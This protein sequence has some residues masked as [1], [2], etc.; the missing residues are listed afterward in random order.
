MFYIICIIVFWFLVLFLAY[1]FVFFFD[2]LF[3]G[4]LLFLVIGCSSLQPCII[5]VNVKAC[6]H[7]LVE[8]V[9]SC[10]SSFK[11][12]NMPAHVSSIPTFQALVKNASKHPSCYGG[13]KNC[14]YR[15]SC[16]LAM[17]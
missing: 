5:G 13:I 6:I 10:S 1:F 4:F 15:Q 2:L 9:F 14:T 11:Y 16:H 7:V 3:I 17:L 12:L 8:L